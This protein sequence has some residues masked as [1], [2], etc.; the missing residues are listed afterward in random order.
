[1]I[2]FLFCILQVCLKYY[3]RYYDESLKKSV[4]PFSKSSK[5]KIIFEKKISIQY[6]QYFHYLK[7]V[8]HINQKHKSQTT[9]NC[10]LHNAH[11]K[12]II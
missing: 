5:F 2:L 1:M 11:N 12:N 4:N 6:Q 10:K 9:T 8:Q 7:N 3:D